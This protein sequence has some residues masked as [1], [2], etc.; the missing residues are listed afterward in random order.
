M[1]TESLEL[2]FL[3]E[4]IAS[5]L[6]NN[7]EEHNFAQRLIGHNYTH[8]KSG[9]F[10]LDMSIIMFSLRSLNSSCNVFRTSF[11]EPKLQL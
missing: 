4:N 2:N 1:F 7:Y 6:N 8:L 11:S 9:A 3:C 5:V 10:S